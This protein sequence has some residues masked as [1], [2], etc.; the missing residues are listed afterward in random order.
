MK[1]CDKVPEPVEKISRTKKKKQALELQQLGEKL[2]SISLSQLEGLNLSE[3]LRQAIEDAKHIKSHEAR[4][5][6]MQYIG[7]LM[8]SEDV[9]LIRSALDSIF[10]QSY[11]QTR[12][13][14]QLEQW[15]DELLSGDLDR[16]DLLI[17]E[18]P[19]LNRQQLK[20][21]IRNAEKEARLQQPPK[22]SRKLFRCLRETVQKKF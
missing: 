21:L 5:R 2:V 19:Q 16:L 17:K 11:E 14:K 4:R 13:F 6:Q 10:L 3:E 22:S 12:R 8:R 1:S 9:E 18:H 7:S 20:Q 15:R